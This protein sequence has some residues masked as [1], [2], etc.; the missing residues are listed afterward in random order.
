VNPTVCV[1]SL[2]QFRFDGFADHALSILS[3]VKMTRMT[4]R[5]VRPLTLGVYSVSHKNNAFMI[6]EVEIPSEAAG[7]S[8]N[9]IC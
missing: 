7:R 1:S 8:R 4:F 6:E 5:C 9:D 2:R 3:L